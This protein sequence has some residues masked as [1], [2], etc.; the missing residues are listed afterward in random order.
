[1]PLRVVGASLSSDI[2][3]LL[4]TVAPCDYSVVWPGLSTSPRKACRWGKPK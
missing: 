3:P 4:E 2:T 1:M